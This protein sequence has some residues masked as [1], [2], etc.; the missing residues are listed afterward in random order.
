MY[1]R[2]ITLFAAIVLTSCSEN[3]PE[4][5]DGPT[6]TQTAAYIVFGLEDGGNYVQFRGASTAKP[7]VINQ[8]SLEPL[9]YE[10]IS[11]DANAASLTFAIKKLDDCNYAFNFDILS[12]NADQRQHVA[13][14]L[15]F[16][17]LT[18]VSLVEG[19]GMGSAK[20][21]VRLEGAKMSCEN[22]ADS[23]QMCNVFYQNQQLIPFTSA[24]P[25][26]LAKS[27]TFFQ[28]SFCKGKPSF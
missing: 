1:N 3:A 9:V 7:I 8:K 20:Y 27:V 28:K 19:T 18:K 10:A 22:T 17:G 26:R 5:A 24:V 2:A 15:D 14:T 13:F 12:K 21:M 16:S 23:P 11:T 25:D 4:A 6:A